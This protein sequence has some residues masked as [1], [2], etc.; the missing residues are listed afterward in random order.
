MTAP[1]VERRREGDVEELPVLVDH[2]GREVVERA[3]HAA[4]VARTEREVHVEAHREARLRER[5]TRYPEHAVP[6]L[7]RVGRAAAFRRGDHQHVVAGR[8]DAPGELLGEVS[9]SARAWWEEVVDESEAHGG[10]GGWSERGAPGCR[11]PGHFVDDEVRRL[12]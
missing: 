10:S 11:D 9:A 4:E 7:H 1:R 3:P 5:A 2:L 12:E 8:G 6:V